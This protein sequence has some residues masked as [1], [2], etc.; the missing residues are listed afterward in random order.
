M[1]RA[2][3]EGESRRSRRDALGEELQAATHLRWGFGARPRGGRGSPRRS[4]PGAGGGSPSASLSRQSLRGV[5]P[6]GSLQ[7]WWC[8]GWARESWR[9]GGGRRF[10]RPGLV[11]R[12]AGEAED[13]SQGADYMGLLGCF[14]STD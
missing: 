7:G 2:D 6:G 13:A 5:R 10:L 4:A 12:A 3:P 11:P 14:S 9:G 1:V 8:A